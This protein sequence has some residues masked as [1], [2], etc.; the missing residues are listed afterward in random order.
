MAPPPGTFTRLLDDV[1]AGDEAAAAALFALVYEELRRLAATALRGE[2]RDHTLQPTA[3]VHEAYLRLGDEPQARWENRA[4]F[5]A[6]AARAM[7]RVL[8]DH[9]RA[10][11][12]QKR[13]SGGAR[14]S[15]EDIDL[16]APA[17]NSDLDLVLLDQALARL[18]L[19]D[20][21]QG[22]MVELRFFGGLTVDETAALLGTS[23]RTVKRDW[24]MARAWLKREMARLSRS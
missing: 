14:V 4:H 20:P 19:I 18:S 24:R 23:A 3:L 8:V 2:R 7:R 1:S 15:L 9:A 6:V 21:R 16:V 11:K 10:R 17:P 5:V 12:A 22:R 13:G